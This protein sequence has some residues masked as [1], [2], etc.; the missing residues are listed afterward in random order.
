MRFREVERLLR[1]TDLPV[2]AIAEQTGIEAAVHHQPEFLLTR[3][4]KVKQ[5]VD[6]FICKK[7]R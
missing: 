1:D 2:E 7:L 4:G 5:H 6:F 3:L